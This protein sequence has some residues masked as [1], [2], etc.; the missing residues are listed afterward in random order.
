ML[1]IKADRMNDLE[2]FGFVR[3]TKKND[4]AYYKYIGDY[5]DFVAV[6]IVDDRQHDK[7]LLQFEWIDVTECFD[8]VIILVCKLIKADMVEEV[9]E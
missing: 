1:R 7:G 4:D 5:G 3:E 8:E 6:N 9:E 2:K